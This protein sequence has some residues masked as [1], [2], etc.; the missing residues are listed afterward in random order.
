MG[1]VI[2][3]FRDRGTKDIFL[4]TDS[5]YARRICPPSIWPAARRK[6]DQ[7]KRAHDLRELAEMPGNRLERL[8]GDRSGQHSI[9]IN[10]QYRICFRWE[11]GHAHE[12]QITDYHR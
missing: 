5:P 6:L 11:E 12:V 7:I 9:R 4:G 1:G 3:S 8:R 10:L 2:K